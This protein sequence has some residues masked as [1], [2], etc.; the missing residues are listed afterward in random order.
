M[1]KPITW[2][3]A[4]AAEPSGLLGRSL[5]FICG[6]CGAPSTV[7]LRDCIAASD[8][9]DRVTAYCPRCGTWNMTEL[10]ES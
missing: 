8:H 1:S 7:K 5:S 6:S 4:H 2:V 9:H 3:R 10:V